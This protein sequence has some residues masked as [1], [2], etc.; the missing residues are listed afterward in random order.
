MHADEATACRDCA[1][2]RRQDAFGAAGRHGSQSAGQRSR[3]GGCRTHDLRSDVRLVPRPGGAR[4]PRACPRHR[5]LRPRRRR[6]R[7]VPHDSQ[8]RSRQPDAGVSAPHRR[9]GVADRLLHP[10]ARTPPAGSGR[11]AN[12]DRDHARRPPDPRRPPQRGHVLDPDRRRR[13]RPAVVRQVGA[14]RGPRRRAGVVCH[15]HASGVDRRELRSPRQGGPRAAELADVLGRLP[16]DALFGAEAD[17][18]HERPAPPGRVDLSDARRL[19]ARDDAARRGRRDVRHTAG[20]RRRARRAHRTSDLALHAH[21]ENAQP[22][23]DQ[24]V[25]PRRRRAR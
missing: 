2:P 21:A 20:R 8:R 9:S 19:R 25:Q 16:R 7:A 12:R 4:R 23:R 11:A 5:R 1:P 17:R 24:P 10:H 22:V 13:R 3:G 14:R 15:H 18:R 6:W